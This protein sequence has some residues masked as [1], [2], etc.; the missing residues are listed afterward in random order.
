MQYLL[1]IVCQEH[2]LNQ[3]TRSMRKCHD[4]FFRSPAF[5]RDKNIQFVE[6]KLQKQTFSCRI[7]QTEIQKGFADQPGGW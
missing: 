7:P 2:D 3:G 1:E 4:L 5:V 6:C